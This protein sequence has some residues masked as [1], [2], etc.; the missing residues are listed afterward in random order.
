MFLLGL[1]GDDEALVVCAACLHFISSST[2]LMSV[3]SSRT[4]FNISVS[5]LD[6]SKMKLNPSNDDDE[7]VDDESLI[8][9]YLCIIKLVMK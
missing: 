7:D 5:S 8:V 4:Y 9:T 1:H 2:I 3:L 6:S